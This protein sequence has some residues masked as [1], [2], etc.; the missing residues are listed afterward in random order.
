MAKTIS[1]IGAGGA[2]GRWFSDYFSKKGFQVKGFDNTNPVAKNIKKA[3]SLISAIL[4]V[5]YVL[6]STPTK[7]TPEIIRLISKEMKRIKGE[8]IRLLNET[9]VNGADNKMICF[10]HP[11]DTNGVLIEL[12]KKMK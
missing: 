12:C 1:I 8:G 9:P 6:L 7:K 11:K 10:L 2:M 4:N 3:E 5:D